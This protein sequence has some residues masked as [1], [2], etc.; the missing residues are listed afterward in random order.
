VSLLLAVLRHAGDDTLK[1]IE[2]KES[3]N[4][5]DARKHAS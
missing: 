2:L 3:R 5:F 4:G 1:V